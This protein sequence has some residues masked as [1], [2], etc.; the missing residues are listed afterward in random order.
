[1]LKAASEL[2]FTPVSR[3][4][5]NAGAGLDFSARAEMGCGTADTKYQSIDEYLAAAAKRHPMN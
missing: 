5:V 1:M 4:R 3:P 2:G